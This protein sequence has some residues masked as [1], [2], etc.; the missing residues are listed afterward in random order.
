LVFQGQ[1]NGDF[2]K[3]KIYREPEEPAGKAVVGGLED[4]LFTIQVK[5]ILGI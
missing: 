2:L 1:Y 5:L 3:V 4:L